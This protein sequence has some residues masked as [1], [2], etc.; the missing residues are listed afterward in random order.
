MGF[1]WINGEWNRRKT[2]A[3]GKSIGV[4]EAEVGAAGDK[5]GTPGRGRKN[6][7]SEEADRK[8]AVGIV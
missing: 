4:G 6:E 2:P 8:F 7:R 5:G 3:V 1:W